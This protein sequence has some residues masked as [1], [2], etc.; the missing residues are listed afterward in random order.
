MS[1]LQIPADIQSIV[2]QNLDIKSQ[3]K[4]ACTCKYFNELV[5]DKTQLE[6][7]LKPADM[8]VVNARFFNKFFD[9]FNE[10][11]L[12]LF[13]FQLI[14]RNELNKLA[15]EDNKASR[16][17]MIKVANLLHS[18]QFGQ[19][20][21]D[22]KIDC[23]SIEVFKKEWEISKS[24]DLFMEEKQ[25]NNFL[26]FCKSTIKLQ[27]LFDKMENGKLDQKEEEYINW[28]L[29]DS[30]VKFLCDNPKLEKIQIARSLLFLDHYKLEL[31]DRNLLEKIY[32]V[33]WKNFCVK[34]LDNHRTNRKYSW[35]GI[36]ENV[37]WM[38]E[39]MFKGF[40]NAVKMSQQDFGSFQSWFLSE[41]NLKAWN[42]AF[43]GRQLK[44]LSVLLSNDISVDSLKKFISIIKNIDSQTYVRVQNFGLD[45]KP[46]VIKLIK[47][48]Y[49]EMEKKN[50]DWCR[51]TFMCSVKSMLEYY[52]Y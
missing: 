8:K 13:N 5:S 30:V 18:I 34:N 38:P 6:K 16:D 49:V 50:S 52:G 24:W 14:S 45:L 20:S 35:G 19:Y 17:K 46:E 23:L 33:M 32:T 36:A 39:T 51:G 4:L 25:Y 40:C 43:E 29:S 44:K 2:I 41:K 15:S 28:R 21:L 31:I 42:E 11:H 26:S 12:M 48:L 7:R 22:E 9:V 27:T 3:S 1:F 37:T 47:D 10:D